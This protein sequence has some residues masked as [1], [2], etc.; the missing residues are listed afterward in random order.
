MYKISTYAC[1]C[2]CT[3]TCVGECDAK[4]VYTSQ[5]ACRQETAEL[6]VTTT[7]SLNSAIEPFCSKARAAE[8]PKAIDQNFSVSS[9]IC[10]TPAK[11][12]MKTPQFQT[13]ECWQIR[14]C[15]REAGRELPGL[16]GESVH[17]LIVCLELFR[18]SDFGFRRAGLFQGFGTS[19]F[20]FG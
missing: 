13:E 6:H 10:W 3:C 17:G 2:I 7:L 9:Q 20:G 4:E 12:Q 5:A 14:A 18:D 16:P 15:P 1:M 19:G 11:S 8:H